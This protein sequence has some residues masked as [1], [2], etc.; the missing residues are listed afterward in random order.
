MDNSGTPL[1][2]EERHQRHFAE[3]GKWDEDISLQGSGLK[4][5]T[6]AAPTW[7]KNNWKWVAGVGSALILYVVLV[8]KDKGVKK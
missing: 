8:K 1:T 4:S 6:Y 3:T 5:F 7:L 2:E